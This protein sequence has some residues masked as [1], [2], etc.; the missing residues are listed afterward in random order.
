MKKIKYE[1]EST[2]LWE[3]LN[4]ASLS[5]FFFYDAV[6]EQS[7][8]FTKYKCHTIGSRLLAMTALQKAIAVIGSS[9]S[10]CVSQSIMHVDGLV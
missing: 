8:H 6:C 1:A 4:A 7:L 2:S 9:Y 5:L 10:N 3:T